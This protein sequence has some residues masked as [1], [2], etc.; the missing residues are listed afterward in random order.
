MQGAL[1][2]AVNFYFRKNTKSLIF[3]GD[4][5]ELPNSTKFQVSKKKI[6]LKQSKKFNLKR[7]IKLDQVFCIEMCSTY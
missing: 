3:V 6:M 2:N 1:K 7:I 4:P 5:L